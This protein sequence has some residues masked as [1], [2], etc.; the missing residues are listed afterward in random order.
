M[1]VQRGAEGRAAFA[2]RC[3]GTISIAKCVMFAAALMH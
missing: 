2:E 3:E 1:I